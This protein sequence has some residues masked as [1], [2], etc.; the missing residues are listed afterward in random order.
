MLDEVDSEL[1]PGS[2]FKKIISY[3]N[4]PIKSSDFMFILYKDSACGQSHLTCG[5]AA[6]VFRPRLLSTV[7][8]PVFCPRSSVPGLLSPVFRPRSSV[9][10]SSVPRS[11]V[12]GLPSPVFC[13]PVFCPNACLAK[14]ITFVVIP[15][16]KKARRK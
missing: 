6:P 12:P 10:R 2:F 14:F 8:S 4:S 1:D 7:P 3:L 5:R 13:P 9:P 16:H 15:K 11:S